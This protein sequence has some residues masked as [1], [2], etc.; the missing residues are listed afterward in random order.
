[1]LGSY[2]LSIMNMDARQNAH[3]HVLLSVSADS[4]YT[5]RTYVRL[6][7]QCSPVDSDRTPFPFLGLQVGHDALRVDMRLNESPSPLIMDPTKRP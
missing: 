3:C 5:L 2:G 6:S 4:I 1:M 7:C